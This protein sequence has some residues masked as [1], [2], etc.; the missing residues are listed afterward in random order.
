MA[1]SIEKAPEC[2]SVDLKLVWHR[3]QVVVYFYYHYFVLRLD[4]LVDTAT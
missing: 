1:E 4:R 2:V 3:V